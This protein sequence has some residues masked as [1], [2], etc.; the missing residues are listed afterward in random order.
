MF[1]SSVDEVKNRLSVTD[2]V[3]QYIKLQKAGVNYRAVCPFHS[4]KKPSFFVSPAR[5]MWHCFGC[6]AGG[7]I[8]DFVMKIEGV[9]FGDALR[10]LAQKAGV[11]LKR[12]DPKLRTERQRLYEICELAARFFEKQLAQSQIGQEAKKYLLDRKITEDSV[13]KWRVGY[14][15]DAWT[16]LCDFLVGQ[17]YSRDE[18]VKAGLAIKKETSGSQSAAG[19]SYFDRFR[20]RIMFP[21]CDIQGQVIGFGGR[22]FKSDDPAK[23]V[24]SPATILYDKGKILYGLDKAKVEVRKKDT[25]IL[26]EGYVD[27]I[28]VAQSSYENVVATSGTA[29]TPYQLQLL[30][31]YSENLFTAFDMDVAGDTATKRGIDLA[32]A[33]GFNVKVIVMPQGKDPADVTA[34]NPASFGELQE[35]ASSIMDFYFESARLKYDLQ[36]AE[37]KTRTAKMLLPI[38]KRIPNAIEL[39]HWRQKLAELL[40][41]KEE[42]VAEELKKSRS[43][44]RPDYEAKVL[45]DAPE[46][47]AVPRS[48]KEI[49]EERVVSLLLKYKDKVKQLSEHHRQLFSEP[50]QAIIGSLSSPVL[51]ASFAGNGAISEPKLEYLLLR[52]ESEE[53]DEEAVGQEIAIA[54]E[55]LSSLAVRNRLQTVA[56]AIKEA[57]A[58]NDAEKT[59]V[60]LREF[61][62]LSEELHKDL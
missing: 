31:R 7:G 51:A 47:L 60:L 30:K 61:H 62:A 55:E 21:V 1:D 53:N 37:G 16:S 58:A 18:A 6:G 20:G 14:S 9:E 3:G 29:L 25:C 32:Q 59:Q 40:K 5:Q 38:L 43:A 4:E 10:F 50:M 34:E 56:S 15:P 39:A 28:M 26:V 13:K 27:A 46:P 17:G 19:S 42:D 49:L 23:Y 45:T 11:E 48:R 22:V 8:F 44:V 36:S 57:E 12:Q 35:K 24:N 33:Q 54:L 41:I 52:A 2:V